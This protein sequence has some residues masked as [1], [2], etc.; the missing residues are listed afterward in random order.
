M[1]EHKK[2]FIQQNNYFSKM[3]IYSSLCKSL[4]SLQPKYLKV[5]ETG[6]INALL[7]S[8]TCLLLHKKVTQINL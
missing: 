5:P 1:A 4:F 3:S 2:D 8:M 6:V 7:L